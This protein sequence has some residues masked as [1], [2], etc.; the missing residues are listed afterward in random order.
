MSATARDER[1]RLR[2][3][4]ASWTLLPLVA[5]L[6]AVAGLVLGDGGL[7]GSGGALLL[8]CG[9][10]SEPLGT[11]RVLRWMQRAAVRLAMC[12]AGLTLIVVG[13]LHV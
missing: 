2:R 11:A 6:L 12:A 8:F 7:E 9:L 1:G 4:L 10:L 5:L 3:A 13:A